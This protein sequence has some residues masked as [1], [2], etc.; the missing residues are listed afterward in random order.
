V[1]NLRLM[2]AQKELLRKNDYDFLI[3]ND[4]IE[5]AYRKLYEITKEILES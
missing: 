1:I 4:D 5:N 3:Y 2:N